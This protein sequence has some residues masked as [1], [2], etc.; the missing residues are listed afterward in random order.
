MSTHTPRS[1]RVVAQ[2]YVEIEGLG[3]EIQACSE[4]EAEWYAVEESQPDGR[5]LV[6][7]DNFATRAEA[8]RAIAKAEGRE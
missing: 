3:T 1:L 8:A 4:Q 2:R 7:D 5:W 6:L